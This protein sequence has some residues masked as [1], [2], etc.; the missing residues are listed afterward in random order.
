[1]KSLWQLD[2]RMPGRI[3]V[4]EQS[5]AK[6]S[7]D[8]LCPP[9]LKCPEELILALLRVVIVWLLHSET[10]LKESQWLQVLSPPQ[11][12]ASTQLLSAVISILIVFLGLL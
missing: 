1:M 5:R 7:G 2:E 11:Y 3:S 4:W 10:G 9:C 12:T 6:G 8:A